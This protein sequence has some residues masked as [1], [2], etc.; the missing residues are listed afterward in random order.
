M[1]DK[2]NS[3]C[4]FVAGGLAL[5]V[6]YLISTIVDISLWKL[7]LIGAIFAAIIYIVV[8]LIL[9]TLGY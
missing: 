7:V 1:N 9:S 2:A 5:I 4:P 8:C 3:V 6:V